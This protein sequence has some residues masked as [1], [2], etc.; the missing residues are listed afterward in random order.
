MSGEEIAFSDLL[1]VAVTFAEEIGMILSKNIAG[2]L[3]N[4]RKALLDVVSKG[5]KTSEKR[6][7]LDI[8]ARREGFKSKTI[9]GIGFVRIFP[10]FR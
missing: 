1:D 5:S 2:Q 4:D 3:L 8:A 10:K 6:M 9:S 7:M